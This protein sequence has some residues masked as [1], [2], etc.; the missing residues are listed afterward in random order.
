MHWALQGQLLGGSWEFGVQHREQRINDGAVL[1]SL[2]AAGC[3]CVFLLGP[4]MPG[5]GLRLLPP[6]LCW[7]AM[8]GFPCPGGGAACCL[9]ACSATAGIA[10]GFP[11]CGEGTNVQPPCPMDWAIR[12]AGWAEELLAAPPP[13]FF[14]PPLHGSSLLPRREK[15]VCCC[16]YGEARKPPLLALLWPGLMVGTW[17]R[18][19]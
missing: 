3:V 17:L 18:R 4:V 8:R 5:L 16:P 2:A 12:P 10:H 13:S 7:E 1:G 14:L 15:D 11:G 6:Q 9:S 19:P